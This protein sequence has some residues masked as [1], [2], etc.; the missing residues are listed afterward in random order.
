MLMSE[1]DFEVFEQQMHKCLAHYYD[2]TFLH[3]QPLIRTLVPDAPGDA[4]R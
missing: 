3:D 1:V 4:G 2:Y